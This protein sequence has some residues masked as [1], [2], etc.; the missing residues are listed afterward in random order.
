MAPDTPSRPSG[1]AAGRK[2]GTVAFASYIGTTIEWYDFFIYGVA[3]TLVFRTQFF[4]G[5]SE[6]AG[7]LA[8]LG[9]FAVGFIARSAASSWDTS[10]TGWGGSRCWSS[11]CS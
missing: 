9:T 3:A 7:T 1:A 8:A 4:P 5:F 10:A 6:T 11:R 2:P